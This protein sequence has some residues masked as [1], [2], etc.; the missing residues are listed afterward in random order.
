MLRCGAQGHWP[1]SGRV[2]LRSVSSLSDHFDPLLPPQQLPSAL[3]SSRS[4]PSP[5]PLMARVVTT[6]HLLS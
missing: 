2:I 4:I 3:A 6:V 5:W 1:L